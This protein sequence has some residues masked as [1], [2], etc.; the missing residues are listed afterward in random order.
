N[1][2]RMDGFEFTDA[3]NALYPELKGQTKLYVVSSSIN[4]DDAKRATDHPAI[5]GFI[6]KPTTREA[7][8]ELTA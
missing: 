8:A 7:L 1:M 2:P 6:P 5:K 4:P 3:F